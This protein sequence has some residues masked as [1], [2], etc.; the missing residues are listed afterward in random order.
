MF[1]DFDDFDVRD[2]FYAI[3]EKNETLNLILSSLTQAKRSRFV[4]MCA[5]AFIYH[6]SALDGM[7]VTNDEIA[8]VFNAEI[9]GLYIRSKVM[10]EISNHRTCLLNIKSQA[11]RT[12]CDAGTYRCDIVRYDEILDFHTALYEGIARREAGLLRSTIPLHSSHFHSFEHPLFVREKLQE[13]CHD[14]ENAEFRV[15]PAINQAVLFH[16]QFMKIFPFTEGSGKVG[17]LLMNR[18]LLQGRYDV[19]IIHSSER[20]RYYEA[21]KEGPIEL[22]EVLLDNMESCLNVQIKYLQEDALPSHD[23]KIVTNFIQ[24][25]I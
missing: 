6:D 11:F 1:F 20:Q 25:S 15:Q 9:R 21:L 16:H 2:R 14:T 13:L 3:E 10:Q 12:L 5:R 17:R 24:L 8:S 22:R 18:F 7:V 4:D 19:A 23:D